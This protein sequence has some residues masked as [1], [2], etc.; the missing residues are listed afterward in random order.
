MGILA[1][2]EEQVLLSTHVPSPFPPGT[3]MSN[4][5]G[6][7]SP[8]FAQSESQEQVTRLAHSFQALNLN[9]TWADAVRIAEEVLAVLPKIKDC[10]SGEN[11]LICVA[12]V[13]VPVLLKVAGDVFGS[14][15]AAFA[16]QALGDGRLLRCLLHN[17]NLA[18]FL[19]CVA[20]SG[21][22]NLLACALQNVNLIAA[23]QCLSISGPPAP[24]STPSRPNY[25]PSSEQRC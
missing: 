25:S 21:G 7:N 6:S 19:S 4:V 15:N 11:P 16:A 10:L 22:K 12:Q 2:Y 18:G 5:Y 17:V 8:V 3:I 9:L 13:V 20:A 24:P 23:F 14:Q 1:W